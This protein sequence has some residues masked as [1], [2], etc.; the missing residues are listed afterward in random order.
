MARVIL[1]TG[2]NLGDVKSRLQCAQQQINEQIGPV[3]RCSH[4]YESRPWGFDAETLF[5]NQVL[6]AA[7]LLPASGSGSSCWCRFAR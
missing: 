7:V 3:L 2:G 5:S 6:E 1:L 4:R